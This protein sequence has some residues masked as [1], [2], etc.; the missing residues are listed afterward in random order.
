MSKPETDG[1]WVSIEEYNRLGEENASLRRVLEM[2]PQ[3]PGLRDYFASAALSSPAIIELRKPM[4]ERNR[5]L[6]VI[7][8]VAQFAYEIADAML[9]ARTL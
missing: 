1:I 4:M 7:L 5:E 9:K 8:Y 3:P 2:S 6:P